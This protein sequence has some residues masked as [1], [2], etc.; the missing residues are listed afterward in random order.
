VLQLHLYNKSMCY[1]YIYIT[2]PCVTATTLLQVTVLHFYLHK[3]SLRHSYIRI[4]SQ[5]VT[6]TE[7]WYVPT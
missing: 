5:R 1:S 2:S 4:T 6:S 7:L 3:K